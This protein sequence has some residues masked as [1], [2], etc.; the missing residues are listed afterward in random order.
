[1]L[2]VVFHG[3]LI[4]FLLNE[5]GK[6]VQT[7]AFLAYL[8]H[9]HQ[10]PFLQNDDPSKAGIG[11]NQKQQPEPHAPH[12]IIVPVSVLPNWVR[13][14]ENFAPELNVVK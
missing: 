8:R 6:T 10:Q 14:F 1:M 7:I 3:V 13:E 11:M 9:Q 4:W 5:Q 2:F 12:L